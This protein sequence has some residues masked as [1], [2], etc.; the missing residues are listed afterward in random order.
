[1]ESRRHKL[2]ALHFLADFLGGGP[3]LTSLPFFACAYCL[4]RFRRHICAKDNYANATSPSSYTG[5]G[6]DSPPPGTCTYVSQKIAGKKS[7]IRSQIRHSTTSV[8]QRRKDVRIACESNKDLGNPL[9]PPSTSP[10]KR[11]EVISRLLLLLFLCPFLLSSF[12]PLG[13]NGRGGGGGSDC[14][15]RPCCRKEKLNSSSFLSLSFL[16]G[17]PLLHALPPSLPSRGDGGSKGKGKSSTL[18]RKPHT[19]P[20]SFASSSAFLSC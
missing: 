3:A 10:A 12:K 7:Y 5:D 11:R 1:M 9:H 8:E 17:D 13:P 4:L 6:D 15:A 2:R 19:F 20:H 18:K 14:G 16:R